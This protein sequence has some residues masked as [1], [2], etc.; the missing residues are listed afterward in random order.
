MILVTLPE[1]RI[2]NTLLFQQTPISCLWR[3]IGEKPMQ[4]I[5]SLMAVCITMYATI[6]KMI[7]V[8]SACSARAKPQAGSLLYMHIVDVTPGHL[9]DSHLLA[10]YNSPKP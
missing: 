6:S 2:S 8:H 7:V 4:I 5:Y 10:L 1:H 9:V 3:A